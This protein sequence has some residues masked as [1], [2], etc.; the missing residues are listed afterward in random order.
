[1]ILVDV[2][3]QSEAFQLNEKD[4]KWI[5]ALASAMSASKAAATAA[6]I[7]GS[8]RDEIYRWLLSEKENA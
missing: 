6:K 5:R 4:K 1:M 8:T 7:V 2:A 3:P